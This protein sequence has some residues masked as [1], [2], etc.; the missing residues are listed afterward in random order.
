MNEHEEKGIMSVL[1][2][3]GGAIEA[4]TCWLSCH[5]HCVTKNDLDAAEQRLAK[6]IQAGQQPPEGKPS[7]EIVVG[8]VREQ[9]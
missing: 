3:L 6:L 1:H 8:P 2:K 9:Q 5:H 4:L 7:V